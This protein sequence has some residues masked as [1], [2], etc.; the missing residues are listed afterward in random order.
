M[1]APQIELFRQH[2]PN[3]ATG[4]MQRSGDG[5]QNARQIATSDAGSRRLYR[6]LMT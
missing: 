2:L 4:T 5:V 6:E 1:V 3:L